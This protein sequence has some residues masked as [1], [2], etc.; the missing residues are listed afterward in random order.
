MNVGQ[1]EKIDGW[2]IRDMICDVGCRYGKNE[3]K[4]ILVR[5]RRRICV[6]IKCNMHAQ[7]ITK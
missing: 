2:T 6:F 5:V 4:M 3:M 7:S 1:M